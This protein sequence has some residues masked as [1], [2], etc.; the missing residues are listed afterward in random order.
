MQMDRYA[1]LIDAGYLL[2]QGVQILSNRQSKARK[3]ISIR[4][5]AGL[6]RMIVDKAAIVLDNTR[7]LRVYWYDGVS[8]RPSDDQLALSELA[9]V[10]L[11]QGIISRSGVQKGVDSRIMADLMELSNHR[12]I[13]DAMVVTGD[14]DLVIAIEHAKMRGVRVAVMGVEDTVVGVAHNQS[15]EVVCVADRVVRIGKTELAPFLSYVAAVDPAPVAVAAA[16]AKPPAAT[17]AKKKLPAAKK[18]AIPKN[19]KAVIAAAVAPTP[20][21]WLELVVRFIDSSAV[22][23][24]A[25]SISATGVIRQAVDG[26][27]LQTGSNAVG[28]TLTQT[29]RDEM[30]EHFRTQIAKRS[31]P[32]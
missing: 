4:D 20:V 5:P 16:A 6:V 10:Q 29:E 27:L 19:Q 14:G 21:N 17:T 15:H 8:G 11:Q 12:A 32:I 31:S 30:R 3:T 22:A 24:T 18:A 9:D 13:C 25:D 2:S 28:R 26:Q 7:L 23:L 1:V